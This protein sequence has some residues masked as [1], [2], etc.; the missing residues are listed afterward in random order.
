MILRMEML[1]LKGPI[2]HEDLFLIC[3]FIEIGIFALVSY[4]ETGH[5][6]A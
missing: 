4:K 5:I 3:F 6:G 2:I 1:L